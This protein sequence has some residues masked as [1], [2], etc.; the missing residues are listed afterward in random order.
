MGQISTMMTSTEK[1]AAITDV[2][3]KITNNQSRDAHG[4]MFLGEIHD[5]ILIF[6]L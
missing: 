3:I 4:K 6:G 2:K 5:L 1:N